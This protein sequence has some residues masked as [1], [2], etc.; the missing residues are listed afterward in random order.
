MLNERGINV[1][2]GLVIVNPT[3]TLSNTYTIEMPN[4][5][6]GVGITH[7]PLNEETIDT[8]L[9]YTVP[10]GG[11]FYIGLPSYVAYVT[12]QEYEAASSYSKPTGFWI[13]GMQ[14]LAPLPTDFSGSYLYVYPYLDIGNGSITSFFLGI[15]H[16]VRK[17]GKILINLDDAYSTVSPYCGP[18]PSSTGYSGKRYYMECTLSLAAAT[19]SPAQLIGHS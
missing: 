19:Y 9:I 17:Y 13:N 4:E 12:F 1:S 14:T 2:N 16:A 10:N 11:F 6:S 5:I 7:G 8:A 18:A 3:Y 15:L